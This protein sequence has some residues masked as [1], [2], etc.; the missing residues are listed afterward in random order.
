MPFLS[1][2]ERPVDS[3]KAKLNSRKHGRRE[4]AR[5]DLGPLCFETCVANKFCSQ[6]DLTN[7]PIKSGTEQKVWYICSKGHKR[8][9]SE[10]FL[11]HNMQVKQQGK[12]FMIIPWCNEQRNA[13]LLQNELTCKTRLCKLKEADQR[14]SRV[15][16]RGAKVA[17]EIEE[18]TGTE[19]SS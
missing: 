3:F 8:K 5:K 19:P 11:W 4:G 10:Q 16:A 1:K 6:H 18:M 7:I 14:A 12:D 9:R 15:K 2:Y 13:Q 17:R